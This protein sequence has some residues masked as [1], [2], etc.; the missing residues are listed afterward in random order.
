MLYMCPSQDASELQLALGM[1]KE[2][3]SRLKDE[4]LTWRKKACLYKMRLASAAEA[5]QVGQE[6]QRILEQHVVLLTDEREQLLQ[7][8][9]MLQDQL[10]GATSLCRG[11]HR[12]KIVQQVGYIRRAFKAFACVACP[13]RHQ[14][15]HPCAWRVGPPF[16]GKHRFWERGSTHPPALAS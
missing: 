5:M 8:N 12:L 9:R 7:C 16:G 14:L 13:H 10:Q 15:S 11:E 4:I 3:G 6:N 1:S 2:E